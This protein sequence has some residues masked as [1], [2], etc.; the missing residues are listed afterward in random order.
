MGQIGSWATWRSGL[1]ACHHWRRQSQTVGSIIATL[2]RLA[3]SITYHISRA[4]AVRWRNQDCGSTQT[5]IQ[6]VRAPYMCMRQSS[7]C[8][9]SAWLGLQEK[10]TETATPQ[11][12]Q[13]HHPAVKEPVG[14]MRQDGKRRSRWHHHSPLVERQAISLERYGARY[15]RRHSCRQHSQR[16]GSSSQSCSDQ[17]EHQVQPAI[18][19]SCVRSGGHWNRGYMAPSGGGTG[20]GDWKTDGQHYRRCHGVQLPAPAVVRGTTEGNAVSFQN[21][22]TTS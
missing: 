18:Q 11:S 7:W 15:I 3:S 8:T 1:V 21:T 12:S 17:Q 5:C 10:C 14:L 2:R 19:H 16:S 4:T 6:S 13:R 20:T 22:F 9:G